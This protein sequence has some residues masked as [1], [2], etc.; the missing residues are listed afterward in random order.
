MIEA[1]KPAKVGD[2][3]RQL[4]WIQIRYILLVGVFVAAAVF[5][6]TQTAWIWTGPVVILGAF[7]LTIAF[8]RRTERHE[9]SAGYDSEVSRRASRRMLVCAG[10]YMASM[11]GA[12]WAFRLGKVEGPWL[13]PLALLPTLFVLGMIATMARQLL[14]ECDEFLRARLITQYLIATACMLVVTTVWGFL[15]QFGLVRHIPL[16]ATMPLVAL[17]L[18]VGQFYRPKLK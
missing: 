16:W 14:E 18:P 1:R 5:L 6:R 4:G 10:L 8:V 15:E 2:P 13:W 9:R 3:E 7:L 11:L 17:F 12:A